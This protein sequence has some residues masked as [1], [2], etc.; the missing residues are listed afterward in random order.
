MPSWPKSFTQID[1]TKSITTQ[2]KRNKTKNLQSE[3]SNL[4]KEVYNLRLQMKEVK[5]VAKKECDF[6]LAEFD[7][8]EQPF[9]GWGIKLL[10]SFQR[11]CCSVK[12]NLYI[13]RHDSSKCYLED[14]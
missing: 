6:A 5:E 14:S 13:K 8:D 3:K 7:S 9:S 1:L 11:S 2:L 4:D 10:L 12:H